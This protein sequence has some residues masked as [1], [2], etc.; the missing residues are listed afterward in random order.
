[1]ASCACSKLP[2]AMVA[3]RRIF[4]ISDVRYSGKGNLVKI[5]DWF[6]PGGRADVQSYCLALGTFSVCGWHV[7]PQTRAAGIVPNV[8][9]YG[10]VA[11]KSSR[12]FCRK[13][14]IVKMQEFSAENSEA[15][16]YTRCCK[17]FFLSN[18]DS[19]LQ[20]LLIHHLCQHPN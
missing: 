3:I 12:I 7:V 11:R 13:P 9:V 17:T 14:K 20:T 1:M 10:F 16:N 15:M 2:R 6:G 8:I 5:S 19:I 4:A 18:S